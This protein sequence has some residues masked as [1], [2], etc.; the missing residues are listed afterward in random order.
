MTGVMLGMPTLREP[1]AVP[2]VSGRPATDLLVDR[3]GR[4]ARDLRISVTTACNLRCTY[5]MPAEGLPV[6]SR[7]EL[8]SADE[9]ARLAG[10]AVHS[11]G[12][13]EIR[14]TGGEPLTRGDL[15]EIVA[16]VRAE[17]G[18]PVPIA[19]TTNAVGLER[20]ALALK[21]AGLTRINVSLDTLDREHFTSLTRR[22]RLPT[23]LAGIE[24]AQRVGFEPIKIN[25]VLLRETLDEAPEL[26][27]WAIARGLKLR[28]IEEMPLDADGTW[29]RATLATA[30]ELLEA[31]GACFVL[32]PIGR[33]DP[34]S[35]AE[36]WLVDDGPAT[37]GIIASV[38]RNFCGDCDR[39][40][41]TA[42]GSI[43][44]CLFAREETDLRA[45]LRG[46]ASDEE[47]ADLWRAAMWGK[48][49][50]HGIDSPD[51]VRPVRSMGAIGG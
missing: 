33:H 18:A 36:E 39:T 50:G 25:A 27:S 49:V 6:V 40:R 2:D 10:L 29:A 47:L 23:V 11:L 31:L 46:G 5:C 19:L 7:S 41:L 45:A 32:S 13:E 17:V 1:R 12:V 42:E 48:A 21:Q 20:R 9:I 15:V 26:L 30:E 43:R 3:F 16:R 4:T 28:F 8:L 24:A 35:P 44:S 51:F 37:V 14:L 34:A 22:D 38:T